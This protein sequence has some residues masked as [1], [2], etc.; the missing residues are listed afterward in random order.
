[1]RDLVWST[2]PVFGCST[3]ESN[4]SALRATIRQNL[5]STEQ[6][7]KLLAQIHTI[8][9]TV[10]LDRRGAMDRGRQMRVKL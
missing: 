4:P 1:M 7:F 5:T 6:I 3:M 9:K 2:V 10:V 8:K